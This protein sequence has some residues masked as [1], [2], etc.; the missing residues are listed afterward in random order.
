MNLLSKQKGGATLVMAIMMLL[1]TTGVTFYSSSLLKEQ[2]RLVADE[3]RDA[4]AY[5]AG[6]AGIHV[7]MAQL[8]ND[9]DDHDAVSGAVGTAKY[10]VKFCEP[11]DDFD[12]SASC[13]SPEGDQ[14][15]IYSKGLSDDD[16]AFRHV[17]AIIYAAKLTQ[18]AELDGALISKGMVTLGGSS[19]VS[20]GSSGDAI[21]TGEDCTAGN[22]PACPSKNLVG[23]VV[24]DSALPTKDFFVEYLGVSQGSYGSTVEAYAA[25]SGSDSLDGLWPIEDRFYVTL[26]E[27]LTWN[28]SVK[29]QHPDGETVWGSEADPVTIVIDARGPDGQSGTADDYTVHINGNVKVYGLVYVLGNVDMGNGTPLIDGS[30]LADGTTTLSGNITVQTGDVSISGTSDS[31]TVSVMGGTLKDWL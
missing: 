21:L 8:L 18:G 3:Y 17:T 24:V 6:M 1:I 7:G 26:S 19:L 10:E 20:S 25:T 27:D 28:N 22:K 12:P 31:T 16:E 2:T 14:I 30:L 23:T 5:E 13:S 4:Q 15:L 9:I 29:S 11:V